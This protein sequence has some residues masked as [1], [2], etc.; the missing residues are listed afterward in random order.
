MGGGMDE[1]QRHDL[2]RLEDRLGYVAEV[3]GGYRLGMSEAFVRV[4]AG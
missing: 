4:V 2:A 3:R 1:K